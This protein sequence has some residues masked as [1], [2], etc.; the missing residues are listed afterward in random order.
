[1][2]RHARCFKLGS[3][4]SCLCVSR[5]SYPRTIVILRVR[6]GIFMYMFLLIR[7][8]STGVLNSWEE[9]CIY[10]YVVAF[11]SPLEYSIHWG[12]AYILSS[13]D[14]LFGWI[15]TLQCGLTC[16]MLQAGIKTWLT[17]HQSDI[18]IY[19]YNFC[20][21][22]VKEYKL[23]IEWKCILKISWDF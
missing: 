17:L 5:I 23:V 22:S 1:M 15:T 3:K 11:N 20:W 6:V 9:L 8:L 10:A 2:L 21:M 19:L 13:I 7:L 18:Y 4:P 16:K 12:G 14:K